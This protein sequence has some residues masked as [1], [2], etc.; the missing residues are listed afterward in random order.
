[1]IDSMERFGRN[2]SMAFQMAADLS[3][4]KPGEADA[5]GAGQSQAG[6]VATAAGGERRIEYAY[7]RAEEFTAA[8][9]AE[10]AYLP[11]L[12]CRAILEA[13]CD[14]VVYRNN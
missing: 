13:A 8:A 1:V 10:L 14:R 4:A 3:D 6:S 2:L 5:G 12:P 11:Q 7:R 9:R